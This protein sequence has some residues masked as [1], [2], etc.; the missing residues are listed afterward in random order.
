MKMEM[1]LAAPYPAVV[2]R[3]HVVESRV[4]AAGM[5]LIEL[6]LGCASSE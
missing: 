1:P 4:V 2:E 3:V 5:L 6:S